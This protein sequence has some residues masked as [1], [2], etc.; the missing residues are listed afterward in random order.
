MLKAH[1]EAMRAMMFKVTFAF[2]VREHDPDPEKRAQANDLIE[3]STPFCKAYPSDEAWWLIGEAIQTYG[4]YGYCEDYPVA[5]IA[6]DVKIYSIWEGTNFIQSL[7]L[8][9]RK[10]T[11]NKGATFAAFIKEMKDFYENN[12]EAEGFEKEFENLGRALKAY[13][14]IQKTI[15]GYMKEKKFSM[16][17]LN[18]HRILTATPSCSAAAVFLDQ[19]LLA[20]QKARNWVRSIMTTTSI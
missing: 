11:M 2:D 19:A 7:D 16:M 6:R 20:A 9:G 5:Q 3:V 4:G 10:W 1:V 8:V 12:K 18:S 13:G 15:M 14:S 17:P